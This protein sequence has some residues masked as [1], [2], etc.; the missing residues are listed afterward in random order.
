MGKFYVFQNVMEYPLTTH[1]LRDKITPMRAWGAMGALPVADEATRA[2]GRGRWR[3]KVFAP[4]STP[5]TATGGIGRYLGSL[6]LINLIN[7]GVVELADTLD[8]GSN[9]QPCKFKSCRPYHK[10]TKL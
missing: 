2:S 4:R 1:P 10:R 5:G 9:G 3:T 7:A 8:L 6:L